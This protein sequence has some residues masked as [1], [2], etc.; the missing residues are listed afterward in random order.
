L[1]VNILASF[2]KK[3]FLKKCQNS[4]TLKNRCNFCFGHVSFG[5]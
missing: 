4:T 2:L 5:Y 1:I 3:Q